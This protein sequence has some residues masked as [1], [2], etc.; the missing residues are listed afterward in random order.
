MMMIIPTPVT[1]NIDK[2]KNSHNAT[3]TTTKITKITITIRVE[4]QIFL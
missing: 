4:W 2:K 1:R 3:T